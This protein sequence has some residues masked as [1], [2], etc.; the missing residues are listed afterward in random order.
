[1]L[2]WNAID[3]VLLDL[4]G[5]LLDLHFDTYFWLD[6]LP[7]RY[8][9]HFDLPPEEAR[10][11]LV[12]RI[13]Q[14]QG[15]LNWYCVDYW[16][17]ELGVDIAAL[18]R[19]ILHKVGFRPHVKDFLQALANSGKRVVIVTNAH[20]KSLQLKFEKTGIDQLVD[21]VICSHDFKLPKEQVQFWQRLHEVEPF[22][23]L[24]TLLIDDNLSVLRSAKA[25]GIA[26]LLTVFQ[27]D[28]QK[29][30]TESEEFSGIDHFD[31]I[32]PHKHD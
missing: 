2:D 24:R 6:H 10:Q 19:E 26:H 30:R 5:T 22:D 27:P 3:T 21:R 17:T 23:P 28:S 9:E 25:Y 18:K 1:M 12:E 13:I 14:E 7:L 4:D 15:T 32:H 20:H 8:A 16:S 29:P 11:K 31:E